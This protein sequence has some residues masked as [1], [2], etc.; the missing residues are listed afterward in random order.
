MLFEHQP[1]NK[2]GRPV[3]PMEPSDASKN[4][5]PS[6]G[7][8]PVG[9][10][11]PKRGAVGCVRMSFSCEKQ[12]PGPGRP[13][14]LLI[15]PGR[16]F[17]FSPQRGLCGVGAVFCCFVFPPP[18]PKKKK[19]EEPLGL[20][21]TRAPVGP[22]V[23]FPMPRNRFSYVVNLKGP[24]FIVNTACSASLVALHSAK[25]HL[26]MTQDSRNRWLRDADFNLLPL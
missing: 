7:W 25:T 12:T 3:F 21:R 22:P 24:S 10:P 2:N 23:F 15:H 19:K 16:V 6:D 14:G 11:K 5:S 20:C 13:T 18:P 17:Q 26:L 9:V 8:F 4:W 1:T